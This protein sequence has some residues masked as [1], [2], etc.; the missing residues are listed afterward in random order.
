MT[1]VKSWEQDML[2]KNK[3][4]EEIL[5][6]CWAYISEYWVPKRILTLPNK[7]FKLWL[8]KFW[9]KFWK[10]VK[11][12]KGGRMVFINKGEVSIS[13]VQGSNKILN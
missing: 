1:H 11:K 3:F 9:S 5:E 2:H 10:T 13:T 7:E 8:E 4:G 12:W 6:F